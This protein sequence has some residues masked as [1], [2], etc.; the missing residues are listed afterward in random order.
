MGA[1]FQRINWLETKTDRSPL[2]NAEVKNVWSFMARY[3]TKHGNNFAVILTAAEEITIIYNCF[4][5]FSGGHRDPN[6]SD[7]ASF[8]HAYHG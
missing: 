8:I 6:V 1:S 2:C 5:C 7:G 3:I 4:C